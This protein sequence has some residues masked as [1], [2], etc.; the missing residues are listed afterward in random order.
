[1][2][3]FAAFRTYFKLVRTSLLAAR[4]SISVHLTCNCLLFISLV[5]ACC[6]MYPR[7][8]F[9]IDSFSIVITLDVIFAIVFPSKWIDTYYIDISTIYSK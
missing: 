4:G 2:L 3:N 7:I 8:E 5:I 9:V 6:Y 1:M